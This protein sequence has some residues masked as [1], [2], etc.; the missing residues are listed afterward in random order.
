MFGIK[1][2]KLRY[3]DTVLVLNRSVVGVDWSKKWSWEDNLY[4]SFK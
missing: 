4:K 1:K 3:K 2:D